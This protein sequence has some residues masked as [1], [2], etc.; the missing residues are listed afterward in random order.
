MSCLPLSPPLVLFVSRIIKRPLCLSLLLSSL[1]LSL[2]SSLP[3]SPLWCA[4]CGQI[5]DLRRCPV[6]VFASPQLCV[7][8]TSFWAKKHF[9]IFLVSMYFVHSSQISFVLPFCTSF[10]L[11]SPITSPLLSV[12]SPSDSFLLL[13]PS[14]LFCLY[15]CC[16]CHSVSACTRC[17]NS[18]RF[19]LHYAIVC[20][21]EPG[22]VGPDVCALYQFY[23]TTVF[24]SYFLQFLHT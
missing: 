16:R 2:T 13:F 22:R 20:Y 1:L 24:R 18:M 7:V 19:V 6:R 21:R 23:T 10:L 15:S 5:A 11:L 12:V 4:Q 17:L 9:S 3:S 8:V 14:C